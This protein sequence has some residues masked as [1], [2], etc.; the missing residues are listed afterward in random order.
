[1]LQTVTPATLGALQVNPHNATA[2]VSAL[3]QLSG[4]APA[5]VARVVTVSAG[6]A[7]AVAKLPAAERTAVLADGP[8]VGAAAKGLSSLSSIPAADVTYLSKN[9]AKVQKAQKEN[10]GQW[11]TW[12]WICFGAQLLFIP[13]VLLMSGFWSPRRAREAER[14]HDQLVERELARLQA[15]RPAA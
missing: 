15:E 7:A 2:Q 8:K 12:W 3:S 4:V 10:P 9:A 13:F 1:M 5:T 14:E 11:Q 6:G